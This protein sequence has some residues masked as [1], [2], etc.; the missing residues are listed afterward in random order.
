MSL[1]APIGYGIP[2]ETM[3]LA[4]AAFPNR[5]LY[6]RMPDELGP[7]YTNHAFADLFSLNAQPAEDPPRLALVLV[8]QFV[9]RL[10]EGQA[11]DAVRGPI[12]WKY[13]LA[14]ELTDPGFAASVL[15]EF[16][17]RL[18]RGSAEEL[19]LSSML[20]LLR[21][22]GLL[23]ARTKQRTDSTHVIAAIRTLNRLTGVGEMLRQALNELAALAPDWLPAQ[24]TPDWF[25]RYSRRMEEYKLPKATSDR[26]A[27]AATIG[28]DGF[29]LLTALYAPNAPAALRE[30]AAVQ[31]LRR[32]WVQQYSAPE[33][34]RP[35]R[36]REEADS[37]PPP[38]R[39]HSPDDPEARYS[40]KR[41]INWVGY[42]VHLTETCDDN[43]PHVSTHVLTTLAT[44]P[45]DAV[46][47]TIHHNLATLD[48]LPAQHL[49][50]SGYTD[51]DRLVT[52]RTQH[53]IELVGP[54]AADGSWQAK[55][56]QGFDISQFAVD[57]ETQRVAWRWCVSSGGQDVV[58][59]RFGRGECAVCSSRAQCTT[60]KTKPREVTLRPQA[61]HTAVQAARL[62]QST[63]EFRLHYAR[64]AGVESLISQG[65]RA[66]DLRRTRSIG[67][68]RTHL[69][70][71]L[72][73]VGI[74]LVRVVAWLADPAPAP[75]RQ[76]H[77]ATLAPAG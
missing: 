60:A 50:D 44:T 47:A 35:V 18:I 36:W 56:A 30:L 4:Q 73:A 64:R 29:E 72:M 75:K 34:G 10:P 32:V 9:E 31:I 20:D 70:Q 53:T 26:L 54:L 17:S 62:R 37:P 68:A 24:I 49:V 67:L 55:A 65:V 27:L 19:L 77:F 40:S 13:A 14:L 33:P 52:S 69:Q 38:Q 16:R 59:V 1:N 57:W 25:D 61:E 15:S 43:A 28:A 45:D 3:R 8:L 2:E 63:A 42:K 51:A 39:I 11:A 66:G 41:S 7:I 74:S 58:K 46:T 71:I 22:R 76:A 21:E 6:M 12:D 23:K 5:N 48:L